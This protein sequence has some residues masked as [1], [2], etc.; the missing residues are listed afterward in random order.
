MFKDSR[1]RQNGPQLTMG[2]DHGGAIL[3]PCAK[4]RAAQRR[5][6]AGPGG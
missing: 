4:R 2:L 6:S 3:D 5:L 1:R